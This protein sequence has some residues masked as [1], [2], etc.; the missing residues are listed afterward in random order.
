MLTPFA[1]AGSE[2]VA[3]KE[4]GRQYIGY[5][6]DPVYVDI[7]NARLEH[8]ISDTAPL[9]ELDKGEESGK[10]PVLEP[11]LSDACSTKSMETGSYQQL[12][13]NLEPIKKEG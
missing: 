8:A 6:T 4:T 7:A 3:A 9:L 5:E 13:F 11:V 10:K 12:S 1:G 2:C